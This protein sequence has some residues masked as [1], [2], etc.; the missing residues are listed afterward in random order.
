MDHVFLIMSRADSRFAPSQWETA[1]LCNAVSHWLVASLESALHEMLLSWGSFQQSTQWGSGCQ[2]DGLTS[3]RGQATCNPKA[4][5]DWFCKQKGQSTS[6]PRSKVKVNSCTNERSLPMSTYSES[7]SLRTPHY[8]RLLPYSFKSGLNWTVK[9]YQPF[10]C[11]ILGNTLT[12]WPLGDLTT[13][14][15]C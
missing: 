10:S 12:H 15:N 7:H 1:L 5:V 11:W 9:D 2:A 4:E 8:C 3:D 13:V 14:S 6:R